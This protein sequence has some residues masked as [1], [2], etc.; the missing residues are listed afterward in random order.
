MKGR[1]KDP[2]RTRRRTGHRRKPDEAPKLRALPA[3][4]DVRPVLE[5]PEHLAPETRQIWERIVATLGE[6]PLREADAFGI[7][8]MVRQYE[9]ARRAGAL[10][11]DYGILSKRTSGEVTTSPLVRAQRDAAAMFL[12]YAEHYGLTVASRMRL[13]LMQLA[14]K[15]LAQALVEDLEE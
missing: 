1:P 14:G 15:T 10:L 7:E 12:R 11:D 5:A 8:L 6:M 3:P 9:V 4:V 2:K 13:G